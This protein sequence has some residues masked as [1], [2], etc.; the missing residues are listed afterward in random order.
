MRDSIIPELVS[1]FALCVA[2][3]TL[4]FSVIDVKERVDVIEAELELIR[5][6]KEL[7]SPLILYHNKPLPLNYNIREELT[8]SL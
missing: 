8:F 7:N 3:A 2:I 5:I 4:F 1:M 6:E